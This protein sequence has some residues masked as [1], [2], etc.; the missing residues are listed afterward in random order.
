[1][2]KKQLLETYSSA[3]F[4]QPEVLPEI[5]LN[6][7]SKTNRPKLSMVWVKEFDGERL[8]LVGR[9]IKQD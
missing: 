4:P 7:N 8:R 2:L 6:Q 9:W 5:S 1:M 3:S